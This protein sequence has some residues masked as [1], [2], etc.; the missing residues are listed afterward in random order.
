MAFV[1]QAD[2]IRDLEEEAR[3]PEDEHVP[4]YHVTGRHR[5][6]RRCWRTIAEKQSTPVFSP[7][8]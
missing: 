3:K 7:E 1:D 2:R 5:S 6:I 4:F 8:A